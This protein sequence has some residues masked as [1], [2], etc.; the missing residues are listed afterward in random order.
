MRLLSMFF[1]SARLIRVSID[2]SRTSRVSS[3]VTSFLVTASKN[4]AVAL[5]EILDFCADNRSSWTL[6]DSANAAASTRAPSS[7]ITFPSRLI[8]SMVELV[9]RALAKD[10][11]HESLA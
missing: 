1:C 11:A 2:L 5:E 4:A 10:D 3:V 8:F 6:P 7:S 9:A